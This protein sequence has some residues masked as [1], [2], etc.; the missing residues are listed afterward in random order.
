MLHR[1]IILNKLK[2]FSI[3]ILITLLMQ[4]GIVFGSNNRYLG[5]QVESHQNGIIIWKVAN[6]SPATRVYDTSS[7]RYMSLEPGDIIQTVNGVRV[8][9]PDQFVHLILTGP[10]VSIIGVWDVRNHFIRFL[11]AGVGPSYEISAYLN[12]GNRNLNN[13]NTSSI[14]SISPK[15]QSISAP[16]KRAE[17]QILEVQIQSLNRKIQDQERNCSEYAKWGDKK[18]GATNLMLQNSARSLLETYEKQ[19][20]DLEMKKSKLESG[21]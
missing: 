16:Q 21:M 12:Q 17:I 20:R 10:P 3:S 7:R 1:L 11:A 4:S 2:I 5:V 14:Q 19:K 8:F 18:P 13:K 15:Y 6:G 9:D